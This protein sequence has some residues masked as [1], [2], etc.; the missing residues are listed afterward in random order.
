M[1]KTST[2]FQPRTT[3]AERRS[4]IDLMRR[5]AELERQVA[6]LVARVTDLEGP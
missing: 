3:P 2:G 5:V 6:D 1:L 4:D